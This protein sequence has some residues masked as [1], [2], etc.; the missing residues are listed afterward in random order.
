MDYS[1][2]IEEK[3]SGNSD[4][5][6]AEL[7]RAKG[8]EILLLFSYHANLSDYILCTPLNKGSAYMRHWS[9]VF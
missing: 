9:A 5:E 7:A 2:L 6:Y 3:T 1:E 8:G 4:S